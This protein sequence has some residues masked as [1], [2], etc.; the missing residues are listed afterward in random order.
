MVLLFA[1]RPLEEPRWQQAQLVALHIDCS[2]FL[3][4]PEAQI[5]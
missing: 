3:M 4:M 2:T 1:L 5:F